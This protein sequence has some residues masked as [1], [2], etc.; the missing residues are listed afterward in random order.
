MVKMKETATT[1]T[2]SLFSSEN[3]VSYST[4]NNQPVAVVADPNP[5]HEP[6]VSVVRLES[7]PEDNQGECVSC[8]RKGVME[9]QAG[10]PDGSCGF[11][12]AECGLG[13]LDRLARA[14]T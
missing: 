11:L 7:A 4:V 14:I 2:T 10:N 1:A 13:E 5:E 9:F 12:C 8:H 6:Y 3:Q